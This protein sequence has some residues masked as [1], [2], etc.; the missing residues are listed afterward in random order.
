M[1]HPSGRF[2]TGHIIAVCVTGLYEPGS[3]HELASDLLRA[4]AFLRSP[5]RSE[6]T[7]APL[8]TL[9]HGESVGDTVSDRLD[10]LG[11]TV[12]LPLPS[13]RLEFP[14]RTPALL[15]SEVRRLVR[16]GGSEGRRGIEPFASRLS[17]PSRPTPFSTASVLP[18]P[19]PRPLRRSWSCLIRSD[20]TRI[21]A[22]GVC[23]RPPG[24]TPLGLGGG[25]GWSWS[26]DPGLLYDPDL[27]LCP[28]S[29][30]RSV[31]DVARLE[32]APTGVEPSL[33]SATGMNASGRI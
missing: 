21:W 18:A 12:S 13:V 28:R 15:P 24:S 6:R 29:I 7:C 19:Q 26:R 4:S 30:G 17:L 2:C 32:P 20:V 33:R 11:E 31:F 8:S 3:R 1:R 16:L 5:L 10:S 23:C 22:S 27:L 25:L 14:N 9:N